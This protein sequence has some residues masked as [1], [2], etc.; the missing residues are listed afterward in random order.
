[1]PK[2]GRKTT[3]RLTT[4]LDKRD[5][6][7]DRHRPERDYERMHPE[8]RNHCAVE[9]AKQHADANCYYYAQRSRNAASGR[10][11]RRQHKGPTDRGKRVDRSDG[12]IDPT[13]DNHHRHSDGHNGEKA[14]VFCDLHNRSGIK[15]FVGRIEGRHL[16]TFSVGH[17]SSLAFTLR[18]RF[19]SPGGGHWT[20]MLRCLTLA[21]KSL[22]RNQSYAVRI[23]RRTAKHLVARSDER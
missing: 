5:T 12:Q 19:E 14:R 18:S 11:V 1:L 13:G 15:E 20:S 4:S 8:R 7:I 10:T 16:L 2:G 22:L 9:K 17:Q 21:F 23:D 6:A 3:D